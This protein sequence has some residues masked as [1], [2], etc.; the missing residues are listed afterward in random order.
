MSPERMFPGGSTRAQPQSP[1]G[2]STFKQAKSWQQLWADVSRLVEEV[3]EGTLF[4][5]LQKDREEG[6][7]GIVPLGT[8]T[9]ASNKT[10]C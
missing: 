6:R 5:P 10:A 2:C 8:R 1:S 9:L 7:L 4:P 3:K